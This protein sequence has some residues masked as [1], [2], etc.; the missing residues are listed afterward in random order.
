MLK[1]ITYNVRGL[2]MIK[3]RRNIF[4]ELKILGP[5]VVFLQ[6]THIT[7]QSKLRLYSSDFPS[8]YQGDTIS[9]RTRGVAIGFAKGTS[10]VL[11][12]RL[13]D[14]E[15]R[16]LFIRGR[17][18]EG[19]YTLANVYAPNKNPMKYFGYILEKLMESRK[20]HLILRGDFNCCM[21]PRMDST[22][23]A[24]EVNDSQLKVVKQKLS[25]YQLVDIWRVQHP[26]RRDYT[27]YSPVHGS[28]SR[29]DVG[30]IEHREI[31]EVV[32]S[33]IGNI[34]FS[35]HAPLIMEMK[36]GGE[37]GIRG[38]WCLNEELIKEEE[39]YALIRKELE[40]YFLVNDNGE[41]SGST[42]WEAHKA[43]IR[44]VLIEMGARKKRE[45]REGIL[46]LTGEVDKLEQEH[47]KQS[48][49][50]PCE[51]Y[52]QL[53]TK[54]TELKKALELDSRIAYSRFVRDRYRWGNKPSK[55]LAK[56]VQKKKTRNFIEKIQTKDG[57]LELSV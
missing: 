33:K 21:D 7:Q 3:K 11:E 37:V 52:Q 34:T 31:D 17:L 47:K 13:V 5:D 57:H 29:I 14:P 8:W 24:Q 27:F 35:D 28:Y 2:N 46:N 18:N 50:Q 25:R 49:Q 42:L 32:D 16:F 22:A 10:F 56:M 54:R 41:V 26:S 45:R 36:I 12:D 39:G 6:E 19:E 38:Q 48:G 23:H 40:N 20:G 9:S 4:N 30:F 43:Y 44:G 53:I 1:F 51:V 15:G 55:F